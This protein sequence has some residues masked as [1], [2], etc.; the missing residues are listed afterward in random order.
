MPMH[1]KLT[2]SDVPD[3]PA[4]IAPVL[5]PRLVDSKLLD[6]ESLKMTYQEYLAKYQGFWV[7]K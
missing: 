4:N 5:I 3:L 2:V 6:L 7:Q 1:K